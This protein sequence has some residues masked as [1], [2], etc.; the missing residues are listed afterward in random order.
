MPILVFFFPCDIIKKRM[1]FPVPPMPSLLRIVYR[2]VEDADPYNNNERSSMKL[3]KRICTIVFLILAGILYYYILTS[4]GD[5]LVN[6][7]FSSIVL[8]FVYALAML[9]NPLLIAASACTVGADYFLVTFIPP[10]RLPGMF[11]S[12]L[13]K[14]CTPFFSTD[15][16]L[17][18]YGWQFG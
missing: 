5:M 1:V 4:G 12:L 14:H 2:V 3:Y 8:C 17:N 13:H 18:G 7:C 9:G 16:V 15:R 10:L 6:S 11:F